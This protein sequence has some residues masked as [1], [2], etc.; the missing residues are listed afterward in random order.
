[1]ATG[2][3][4]LGRLIRRDGENLLKKLQAKRQQE[5]EQLKKRH[6]FRRLIDYL[7]NTQ[8]DLQ[9][10]IKELERNLK[11]EQFRSLINQPAKKPPSKN[12]KRKTRD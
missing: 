4:R 6:W 1:M 3:R 8:T 10:E 9:K 11:N 7:R 12:S 2:K 5:K